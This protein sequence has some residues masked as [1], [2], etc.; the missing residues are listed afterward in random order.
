[1]RELES[2]DVGSFIILYV[3]IMEVFFIQVIF[4]KRFKISEGMRY[5]DIWEKNVL[6]EGK[7]KCKSF[8]VNYVQCLRNN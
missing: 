8:E 4:K 7:R 6:G 5:V 3:E 2:V 1:M